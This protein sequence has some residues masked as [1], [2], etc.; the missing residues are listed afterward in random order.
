MGS[1]SRGKDVWKTYMFTKT[2]SCERW[3]GSEWNAAS[4]VTVDWHGNLKGSQTGSWLSSGEGSSTQGSSVE[5]EAMKTE[6]ALQTYLKSQV[7][8]KPLQQNW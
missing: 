5:P 6:C 4:R 3:E 2:I 1:L 7:T 8:R